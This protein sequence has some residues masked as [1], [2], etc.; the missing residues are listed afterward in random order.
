[1]EAASTPSQ[2]AWGR[3]FGASRCICAFWRRTSVF[4]V[5]EWIL[6]TRP[7]FSTESCCGFA[8]VTSSLSQ[9]CAKK[10]FLW[11][12]SSARRCTRLFGSCR[13]SVSSE[14]RTWETSAASSASPAFAELIRSR[15]QL[16][17]QMKH[18]SRPSFLVCST[19]SRLLLN[20]RSPSLRG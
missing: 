11:K 17:A 14:R 4:E 9:S 6:S 18:L 1:M 20:L 2:F 7:A 8:I 12:P 19:F 10:P 5:C 3:V 15:L 16:P 13:H